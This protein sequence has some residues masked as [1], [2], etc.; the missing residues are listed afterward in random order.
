[1]KEHKQSS[2]KPIRK[3]LCII[4]IA[5][6]VVVEAALYAGVYMWDYACL[7]SLAILLTPFAFLYINST[8]LGGT[9]PSWSGKQWALAAFVTVAVA[10]AVGWIAQNL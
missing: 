2:P 4:L 5:V 1:M 6:F 8:C 9:Y 3:R 10:L 7:Q